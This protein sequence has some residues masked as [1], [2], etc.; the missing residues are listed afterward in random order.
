MKFSLAISPCPND[1]FIFDY[2]LHENQSYEFELHLEDIAQL[3]Q[4]AEEGKYDIIKVSFATYLQVQNHYSLLQSGA[5]LGHGVGPL[6]ISKNPINSTNWEELKGFVNR[7]K[8]AIPGKSTTANLLLSTAFPEAKNKEEV[9]FNEIEEAVLAGKYDMGLVIHESRFTYQEKGLHLVTDMGKWWEDT[10]QLPIPLG[11]ILIKKSIDDVYK[12]EIEK[13]IYESILQA[14]KRY[15]E[16]SDFIRDNAQ[17]MSEEVMK[18]HI[19]LYVNDE[20]LELS[21]DAM[22]AIDKLKEVFQTI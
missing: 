21:S 2:L 16:L 17:E 1:T 8:I 18:S 5:A 9:I 11:C 4:W 19:E 20:S 7:S 22:K 10:Y 14:W 13:A 15:P 6:L 12:I 3:N